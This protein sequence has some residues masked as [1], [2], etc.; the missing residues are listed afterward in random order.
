MYDYIDKNGEFIQEKL[1]EDGYKGNI[2]ADKAHIMSA[3]RN[4][5]ESTTIS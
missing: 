2:I 5:T 3:I 1:K 4:L